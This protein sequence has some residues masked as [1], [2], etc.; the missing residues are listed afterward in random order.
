MIAFRVGGVFLMML[1]KYNGVLLTIT[2]RIRL[3]MQNISISSKLASRKRI[4]NTLVMFD[5]NNVR[6]V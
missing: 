6:N 5:V 4:N 3:Q 2:S 1:T